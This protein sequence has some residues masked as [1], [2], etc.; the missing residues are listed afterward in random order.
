MRLHCSGLNFEY[1]SSGTRVIDNLSFSLE[2]PGFHAIF[3][4]SGAGKTSL[5]RLLAARDTAS[6]SLTFQNIHRILYAYNLERFPGWV[7]AGSHLDRVCPTGRDRL[8][9]DLI[10]IFDLEPVLGSRFARLSMGQQNRMNLLRYLLQDFDLLILDE[11]LA[12][13][14]EKM[15]QTILPAIKSLFP[16]KIFLYISHNLM[17]VARF[18]RDIL[19]L[20]RPGGSGESRVIR[21]LDEMSGNTPERSALDRVMLEIMNAF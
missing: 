13:V 5:A 19:V 11:C 10:Q 16:D 6:G 15:R 1:G 17:E 4:P 21:G 18:C 3:G 9:S 7:A 20:C 8:K 12:N 2:G 14:D